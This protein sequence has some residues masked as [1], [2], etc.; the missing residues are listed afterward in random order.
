MRDSSGGVNN[1]WCGDSGGDGC[2]EWCSSYIRDTDGDANV[3]DNGD[4]CGGCGTGGAKCDSNF[5]RTWDGICAGSTCDGS[6]VCYTG[7]NY[8]ADCSSCSEK[9]TCESTIGS[10]M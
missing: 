2:S 4:D 5:D 6:D 8:Q 3:G 7:S 10:K 1:G 9:D